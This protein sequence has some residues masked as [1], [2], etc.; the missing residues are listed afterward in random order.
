MFSGRKLLGLLDRDHPEP[1]DAV[2]AALRELV[3]PSQI[4]FGSDFPFV[5][6]AL[7]ARCTQQR[8]HRTGQCPETVPRSRV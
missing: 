3:E 8:C 7:V 1:A 2:L 6:L 4:L 5:P